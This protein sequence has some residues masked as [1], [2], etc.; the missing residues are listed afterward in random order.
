MPNNL[1]RSNG[2]T[3]IVNATFTGGAPYNPAVATTRTIAFPCKA[4]RSINDV[5]LTV[6][7]GYTVTPVAVIRNTVEFRVYKTQLNYTQAGGGSAVTVNVAGI[8]LE[9]AAGAADDAVSSVPVE[10][11]NGAGVTVTV[12][13]TAIGTI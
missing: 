2:K 9:R 3:V 12:L 11:P 10:L 6:T 5:Q 13:G 8:N 7:V 4:I 1:S